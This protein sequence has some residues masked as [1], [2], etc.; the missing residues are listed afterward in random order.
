MQYQRIVCLETLLSPGGL[1]ECTQ[2]G[3]VTLQRKMNQ[4]ILGGRMGYKFTISEVVVLDFY[5]DLLNIKY[6]YPE[7][8]L[9]IRDAS[10]P[11]VTAIRNPLSQLP[12]KYP[13]YVD[14]IFLAKSGEGRDIFQFGLKIGYVFQ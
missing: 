12:G 2:S 3:E 13:N 1:C 11:E 7:D 4:L 6:T 9:S 5:L 14:N 10:C 8:N